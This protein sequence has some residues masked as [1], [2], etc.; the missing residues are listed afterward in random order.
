MGVIL[1]AV[2]AIAE[3]AL[4][5]LSLTKYRSLWRRNRLFFCIAEFALM[6]L[7]IL[8]PVTGTKWRFTA[9]LV[10][11]GIR[12]AIFGC[13][14]L[15]SL[16]KEKK[17][18]TT[19]GIIV[20]T[21]MSVIVICFSLVPAF[22][23]TDYDG[24]ETTGPYEVKETQ[25][26]LIDGSRLEKYE[27]DGSNR[28]IPVHIYYPEGGTGEYP[29]VLFA[30]GSFGYYQS[31]YSLYAELVSNGYVVASIDHPYYAF[32]TT[33]TSGKTI[34]VDFDF[35]QTAVNMQYSS[36]FTETEEDFNTTCEWMSIRTADENFVLDKIKAAKSS[37]TLDTAWYTESEDAKAEILKALEMTDT[38]KIGLTGHSI[39]G[40][41][42]VQLGRERDDVTAVIDID[43]T[44]LG[45]EISFN[46]G[47]IGYNPEPYPIP[48]LSLDNAN[49]W[50]SYTGEREQ[51]YVNKYMLD[52]AVDAREAHFD[53]SEHMDF[54]DLPLFAPPLA[55]LLGTGEVD[56]SEF[57]PE[58]NGIILNY[59]DYYLKGEGEPTVAPWNS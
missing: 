7:V 5:A 19:A 52:N 6:L 4:T 10:I 39:G 53:G 48:V 46:D 25:A 8:M 23:F 2:F 12:L 16:V 29:L 27:E 35:M 17:D 33:D 20:S 44:M 14:Y 3:I 59:F 56:P 34:T 36:D 32:F 45:E 47:I 41:A 28:E 24:L 18:K 1:F 37:G 30:H 55:K 22:V 50:Q 15:I 31:N 38:G 58:I 42:A 54:T 13:T 11:L 40:A 43:G 57:I 49:H 9:C 26:I 51:D 21:V